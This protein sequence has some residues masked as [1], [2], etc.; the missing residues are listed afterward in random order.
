MQKL[1]TNYPELISNKKNF[2]CFLNMENC[3]IEVLFKYYTVASIAELNAC[4]VEFLNRIRIFVVY[5]DYSL[6]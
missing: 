4:F 6:I 1:C 5:T 2:I 3:K